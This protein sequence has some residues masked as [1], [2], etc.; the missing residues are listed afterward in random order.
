MDK[1]EKKKNVSY[2]FGCFYDH[3]SHTHNMHILYM[4]T[5]GYGKMSNNY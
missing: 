1:I 5:I 3:K 2:H 4:Y